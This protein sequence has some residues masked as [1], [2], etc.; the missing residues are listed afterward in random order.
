MY[1]LKA[2]Y[3]NNKSLST[4][5]IIVYSVLVYI[6]H[7]LS[8]CGFRLRRPFA[9]FPLNNWINLICANVNHI[10]QQKRHIIQ[11]PANSQHANKLI[12]TLSPSMLTTCASPPSHSRIWCIFGD[13][14]RALTLT[15]AAYDL[16]E[17]KISHVSISDTL[18]PILGRSNSHNAD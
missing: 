9:C 14:K 8:V 3:N 18:E 1:Y 10:G 4:S 15:A 17:A 13:R 12:L 5:H 2:T 11:A 16:S 6:S 7:A